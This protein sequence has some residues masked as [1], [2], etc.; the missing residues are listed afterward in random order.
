MDHSL[1]ALS[2]LLTGE[3]RSS[4]GRT[5]LVASLNPVYLLIWKNSRD[6]P[7]DPA[8]SIHWSTTLK[9]SV[10]FCDPHGQ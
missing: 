7:A 10:R 4:E 2:N 1:P 3:A 5:I 8:A 6:N 9:Y